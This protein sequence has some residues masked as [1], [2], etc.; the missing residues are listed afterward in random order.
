MVLT[1]RTKADVQNGVSKSLDLFKSDNQD[2]S[3]VNEA[4][5]LLLQNKSVCAFSMNGISICSATAD[6]IS[7]MLSKNQTLKTFTLTSAVLENPLEIAHKLALGFARNNSITRVNF[8]N[9][10]FD[11]LGIK[12]FAKMLIHNPY[13]VELR[14]EG[15][16]VQDSSLIKKIRAFCDRNRTLSYDPEKRKIFLDQV[17]KR[18]HLAKKRKGEAVELSRPLLSHPAPSMILDTAETDNEL[19]TSV[20]GE[21]TNRHS[22]SSPVSSLTIVKYDGDTKNGLRQGFGSAIYT[23]GTSYQGQWESGLKNG[24]GVETY[25]GG[26]G[27]YS[28]N[29]Y[30]N[31]RH[32]CGTF[33]WP[34]GHQD[35]RE[36]RFDTLVVS[37]IVR[38]DDNKR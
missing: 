9:I 5:L 30:K 27:R 19:S 35:V 21:I 6:I 36:Y 2:S 38:N 10:N 17:E 37:H 15:S 23:D 29:W 24:Q 32:G 31:M 3:D 28:G 4:C 16:S 7:D 14:F 11:T 20:A 26:N 12:E 1:S 18:R 34:Q 33:I 8:E 22:H 25:S 13:I